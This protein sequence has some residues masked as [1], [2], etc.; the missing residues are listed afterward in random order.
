MRAKK[1]CPHRD[2]IPSSEARPSLRHSSRNSKS[3]LLFLVPNFIQDGRKIYVVQ[4]TI[5]PL[6][7]GFSLYWFSW[8]SPTAQQ[9]YSEKPNTEFHPNRS[10]S[11]Q[12]TASNSF[13]PLSKLLQML[14]RF[15]RN[16]ALPRRLV[17]NS[18]SE[19][20]EI[21][22][23]VLAADTRLQKDGRRLHVKQASF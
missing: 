22:S 21:P 8:T 10:I 11:M 2:L 19:F 3:N 1:S 14:S 17:K 4:Q 7:Y 12:W 13:I 18:Y 16:S 9:H 6:N 20:H 23:N 15:S 5:T